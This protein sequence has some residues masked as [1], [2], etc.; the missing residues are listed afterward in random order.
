MLSDDAWAA[1]VRELVRRYRLTAEQQQQAW[2]IYDAA[3]ER[4]DYVRRRY[5]ARIAPAGT[6]GTDPAAAR[7]E[8]ELNDLIA[9]LFEQF[10]RRLDGLPTRAQRAAAETP[11]VPADAPGR[12]P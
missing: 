8:R 10:K 1:H 12:Q 9:R 6:G 11:Q 3:A 7:A 5:E 2:R 4:R